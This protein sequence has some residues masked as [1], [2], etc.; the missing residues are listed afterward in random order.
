MG[1]AASVEQL[2]LDGGEERLGDRVVPALTATA[3]RQADAVLVGQAPV[4]GAGVLT[5]AVGVEDHPGCGRRLATASV[6]ACVDQVGA[7]VVGGGPADDAARARSMT[8][9]R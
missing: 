5:A 8:V 3:D 7:Q 6:R 1:Q 2:G 4:L 9:A